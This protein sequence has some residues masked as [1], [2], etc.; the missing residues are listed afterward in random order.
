MGAY[1]ERVHAVVLAA[2]KGKRMK[3]D[4]PKVL[5]RVSG[6]ALVTYVLETLRAAGVEDPIIVVGHGAEGVRAIGGPRARFVDQV[7]QRGTGHAVMQA[8]PLLPQQTQQSDPVLVLYGDTP[9]LTPDTIRALLEQHRSSEAAVTMLTAELTDPTGYGRIIRDGDGRIQRIVEDADASSEEKQVREI[10][11]GTYVYDPAAL[12]EALKG[13]VPHNAQ[14][15]YYITDTVSWLLSRGRTVSALLG[16]PEETMGINSRRELAQVEAVMRRRILEGLM[17]QGVTIIDPLTTYVHAGV[18]VGR[19]S[20]IHPQC[21]L[22][23]TTR[24]GSGCVIG[25][26]ARLVDSTLLDQ[27]TVV[28]S[29]VEGSIVGEGT[30]VGPYSHLRPG[31]QVGRFVEIGN[32]AEMK[33]ATVGDYTKVHHQSYLGDA[34]IGERVNIGAGTVTCNYDGKGK[35]PTVIEDGAF[36]GSDTMLIAPVRIGKGAVT[37]AGSVVNKDVPP[38]ALAVGVPARVIKYVTANTER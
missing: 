11:A 33:N 8:L 7:E 34:T 2:G 1:M 28:A 4:L 5:H 12:R 13:L 23:G 6:Q 22:E 3:S 9:L 18:V 31:T 24:I 14:G 38:G 27:V 30:R 36:I 10:N 26:Q 32:F 17:D 16:S 19:D 15:E 35:Y 29:T 20:V 21:H 37:G 25:P